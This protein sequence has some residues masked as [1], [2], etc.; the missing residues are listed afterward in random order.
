MALLHVCDQLIAHTRQGTRPF[1]CARLIACTVLFLQAISEDV[2]APESNMSNASTRDEIVAEE[3]PSPKPIS[4]T[5]R[6]YVDTVPVTGWQDV[7]DA[8]DVIDENLGLKGL[9]PHT[10]EK[11]RK[12]R[13]TAHSGGGGHEQHN[14]QVAGEC[15]AT[16][17]LWCVNMLLILLYRR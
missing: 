17:S 12:Q 14:V 6:P 8:D 7:S 15:C 4:D 3:N 1:E 11:K 10:C 16:A 5:A 9:P 13:H 2:Y